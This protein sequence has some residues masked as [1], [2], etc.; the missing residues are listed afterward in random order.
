MIAGTNNLFLKIIQHA[1]VKIPINDGH[2][3]PSP[4][5]IIT[6]QTIVSYKN[7]VDFG[8]FI[9]TCNIQDKKV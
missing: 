2:Y 3:S 8:M 7:I 5:G 6:D 1:K 4:F 9:I